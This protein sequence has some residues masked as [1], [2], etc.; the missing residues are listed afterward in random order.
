MD[1]TLL[2]M[3]VQL[4]SADSTGASK[5]TNTMQDA[6]FA[7]LLDPSFGVL[8][9]T[10][11]PMLNVQPADP[12]SYAPS[13]DVGMPIT[14][15]YINGSSGGKMAE[16]AQ[17]L[18]GQEITFD[19]ALR[20][21]ENAVADE[22]SE[23]Y[24]NDLTDLKDELKVMRDETNAY[25]AKVAE[26]DFAASQIQPRDDK[27]AEMGLPL[28]SEQYTA[29]TINPDERS[30]EARTNLSRM[31][32]DLASRMAGLGEPW[33]KSSP[34]AG[35]RGSPSVN[36]QDRPKPFYPDGKWE[37][38]KY[39]GAVLTPNPTR[40]GSDAMWDMIDPE[41]TA[42]KKS[43]EKEQRDLNEAARNADLYDTGR[44]LGATLS[45]RTPYSDAMKERTNQLAPLLALFLGK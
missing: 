9:G 16:I 36:A 21:V 34:V 20:E 23:L 6:L 24:G 37:I 27:Y 43:L 40:Y 30:S 12:E 19:Q 29:D 14:M 10:Y 38:D 13:P 31:T 26:A 25:R 8:T 7:M 42:K 39:G 22:N 45:G 32:A 41:W 17:G 35:R 33:M 2:A 4:L 1:P 15:S 44:A 11:D 28:P 5:G 3:L 18:A